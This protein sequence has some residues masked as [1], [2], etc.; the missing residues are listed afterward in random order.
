MKWPFVAR[1]RH[2]EAI[3]ERD[4]QIEYWRA[5]A[6]RLIDADLA[7]RGAIHEPTMVDRPRAK[8]DSMASLIS[9]ALAITEIDSSK[10]RKAVS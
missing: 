7:R 6:E 4:A 3:R 8:V 5:R 2:E 10:S 1:E 9:S